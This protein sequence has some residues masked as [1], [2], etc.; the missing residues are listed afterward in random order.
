LRCCPTQQQHPEQHHHY[1]EYLLH[2]PLQQPQ[3]LLLPSCLLA[4]NPLL[5]LL[6][7]S[8]LPQVLAAPSLH[9][10]TDA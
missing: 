3:Q 7:A 6:Q 2:L 4:P 8:S 1:Q 10:P 9:P 5:Q